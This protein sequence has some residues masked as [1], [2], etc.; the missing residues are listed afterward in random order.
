[1]RASTG[2]NQRLARWMTATVVTFLVL[3][4]SG[5][6]A[7]AQAYPGGG[8][9]PPDRPPPDVLGNQLEHPGGGALP[10]TGASILVLMLIALLC[11]TVGMVAL[12]RAKAVRRAK[13]RS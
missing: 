13:L 7:G 4:G 5:L 6:T 8:L 11:I 9:N 12:R 3:A 2:T 10:F 1:M